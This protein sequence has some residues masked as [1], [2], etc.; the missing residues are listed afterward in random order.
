M[1]DRRYLEGKIAGLESNYRTNRD[2]W[3]AIDSCR[4]QLAAL[5][6]D[7]APPDLAGLVEERRAAEVSSVAR[8]VE[9]DAA[10]IIN[11][12]IADELYDAQESKKALAAQVERLRT[13]LDTVEKELMVEG[14]AYEAGD[15]AAAGFYALAAGCRFALSATP[16]QSIAEIR[17][18]A[19]E[20]YIEMNSTSP[21]DCCQHV[22]ID[23]T[24]SKNGTISHCQAGDPEG[25]GSGC[26]HGMYADLP[27]RELTAKVEALRRFSE[28]LTSQLVVVEPASA[29]TDGFR[30]GKESVIDSLKATANRLEESLRGGGDG[31]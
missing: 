15:D 20:E 22:M 13:A 30:H 4:E 10:R 11:G 5:P 31:Q 27:R 23:V 19:V 2:K 7:P 16:A 17:T 26:A 21:C 28:W 1:P 14:D 9:L 12:R 29:Y 8:R 3:D 25:D 18:A 24:A 6:P